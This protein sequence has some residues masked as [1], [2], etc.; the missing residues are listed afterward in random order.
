MRKRI[1]F[2]LILIATIAN[3][4]VMAQQQTAEKGKK[5]LIAYYSR[6]GMNYTPDGIKDLKVGNTE[7]FAAKIQNII[8]GKLFQIDTKKVYPADYHEC[9][10]EAYAEY[11][12]N[13]RPEMAA[14]VD[15]IALYD[16]I[17]IG[18]PI[19]CHTFPMVVFTF[20]EKYDLSGKTIIPFCTDEG[21]EWG[22]SLEHLRK[23]CPK[24][25]I[26]EG[27]ELRGTKVKDSDE[28]IKEWLGR[29]NP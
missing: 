23:A 15:D 2:A 18:Y 9:C 12:A 27:L 22:Y 17:Y 26:L 7:L 20:L 21:S 11:K 28:I 1:I 8:G 25:N 29:V 14:L 16:T 5:T 13:A 3:I 6:R 4:S 19:W 10:K 24:S